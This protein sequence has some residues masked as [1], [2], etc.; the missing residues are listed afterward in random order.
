MAQ[1]TL[2]D[3]ASPSEKLVSRA[4]KSFDVTDALGRTITLR[5]PDPLA[6]LDFTKAA[7]GREVN[8]LYLAEV[9]H[10]QFIA[11][12]DGDAVATPASDG[13]LRALYARLGDEGNEAAQI[14]VYKN[15]VDKDALAAAEEAVKNS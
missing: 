14:G 9:A 1:V 3:S 4:A 13:E 8:Q 12:I 2:Q 7:G 6:K 10:L 5:K 15:F 11:A